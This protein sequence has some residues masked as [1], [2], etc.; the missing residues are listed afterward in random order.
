MVPVIEHHQGGWN[1]FRLSVLVQKM[2]RISPSFRGGSCALL[3]VTILSRIR[4]MRVTCICWPPDI[5]IPCVAAVVVV[6]PSGSSVSS[7]P[8]VVV[9]RC[10]CCCS[11]SIIF[12]VVVVVVVVVVGRGLLLLYRS[13]PATTTTLK[14]QAGDYYYY[15]RG[16]GCGVLLLL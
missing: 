10:S 16:A 4:S 11:T 13:R 2:L 7:H 15:F 9:S 1:G 5:A 3:Q 8:P 14:G 6:L 12:V